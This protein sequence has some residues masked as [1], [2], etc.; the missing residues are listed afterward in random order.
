[1]T[2]QGTRTQ[3]RGG[4]S[5][6]WLA[7]LAAL[8]LC[9]ALA[10]APPAD[11]G[12]RHRIKMTLPLRWHSPSRP[13][14]ADIAQL[15]RGARELELEAG[16]PLLRDTGGPC[17]VLPS[18]GVPAMPCGPCADRFLAAILA[19]A[20]PSASSCRPGGASRDPFG[21]PVV[22]GVPPLV[23]IDPAGQTGQALHGG[24]AAASILLNR[25]D[26]GAIVP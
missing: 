13:H 2:G 4:A 21:L 7:A 5:H 12:T 1:M 24:G 19:P 6:A 23:M 11:A 3:W 25:P 18:L 17:H 15:P 9:Q 20:P 22:P 10:F 8:W 26:L 14:S 16:E